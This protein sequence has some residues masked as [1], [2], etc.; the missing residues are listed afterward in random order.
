MIERRFETE[1]SSDSNDITLTCQATSIFN[2]Q[3]M[4]VLMRSSN[5]W[6]EVIRL[7]EWQYRNVTSRK[8]RQWFILLGGSDGG[9]IEGQ[10]I[11]GQFNGVQI[12]QLR[13][14]K[15]KE[16]MAPSGMLRRAALV[17]TD[18]SKELR[19]SFIGVTRIREL[20]TTLAVTNNRRTLWRNTKWYFFTGGISSQC[21]SVAFYS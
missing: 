4:S 1:I 14:N 7:L 9:P 2:G 15:K 8:R 12:L 19:S 13:T 20:G 10:I 6:I 5:W 11:L 18:V 3:Y 16:R 17:R 21:A